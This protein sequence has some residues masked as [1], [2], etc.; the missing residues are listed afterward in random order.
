MTTQDLKVYAAARCIR[1]GFTCLYL[2][3]LFGMI[4]E[5]EK[6]LD[7]EFDGNQNGGVQG[8]VRS[9]ANAGS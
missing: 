5:L 3:H 1:K 6:T 9:S 2:H 7:D 4:K 8:M